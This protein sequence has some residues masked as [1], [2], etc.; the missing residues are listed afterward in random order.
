[1]GT[2]VTDAH[3]LVGINASFFD[4]DYN[5]ALVGLAIQNGKLVG[6]PSSTEAPVT[7]Y[8]PLI[9]SATNK[10]I[11]NGDYSWSGTVE[12]VKTGQ[13][14]ALIEVDKETVVP[15]ACQT[16]TDQ[17][18]C[19]VPGDLVH[20]DSS[21]GA[22][23]PAGYGV[24]VVLDKHGDVVSVN[25]TRGTALKPGQTSIQATGSDAASLLSLVQD[26]GRLKTALKLYN[27]G[28]PV[29]LTPG[30]QAATASWIQINDGVNEYP[31]TNGVDTP[32]SRNPLT[33]MATTR[34][35]D[36]ILFTVEGRAT[37]SVGM[38]YPEESAALLDLGA[39]NAVNLD[40]GGS[41]QLFTEGQY[42]TT[43]SDG[44]IT[45]SSG[46]PQFNGTERADGDAIVWVPFPALARG[47]E[48][49]R[50]HTRRRRRPF[51]CAWE[52]TPARRPPSRQPCIS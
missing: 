51:S 52:R 13:S 22:E 28:Q 32:T 10:V 43:S 5:G 8:G 48:D 37:F 26:G 49:C 2:L 4:I 15:S 21:W 3:G 44:Y 19:T 38:T 36:I 33:G 1:M 47:G 25:D 20:F 24:E 46:T 23:T 27:N 42:A 18:Q 14:L 7:P 12:N 34:N 31:Y 41:T 9:D 50:I 17:T 29:H 6:N 40:G 16:L 45:S 11:L 39:W 30:T 35:G